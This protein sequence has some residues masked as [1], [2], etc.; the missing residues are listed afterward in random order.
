MTVLL[1]VFHGAVTKFG[2]DA[3]LCSAEPASHPRFSLA[4]VQNHTLHADT[5]AHG[6]LIMSPKLLQSSNTAK[7]YKLHSLPDNGV[8][9]AR[10]QGSFSWPADTTL[11]YSLDS[12]VRSSE[13]RSHGAG[14]MNY[15]ICHQ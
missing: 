1:M 4:D 9:F 3:L 14:G 10:H 15:V 11:F 7:L 2:S 6:M 8:R 13:A 5:Y 12:T